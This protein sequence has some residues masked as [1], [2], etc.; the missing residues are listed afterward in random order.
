MRRFIVFFLAAVIAG[1]GL[2]YL[3]FNDPAAPAG[4]PLPAFAVAPLDGRQSFDPARLDGPYLLNIWGSWCAPCRLEHAALMALE[5]EG[6]AIYGLSWRDDPADANAFLD[7][8]GDPYR[9]VMRIDQAA[10]DALGASGAPETLVVADGR[11]LARWPGPLTADALRNRIYPALEQA[12][13]R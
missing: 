7:E 5:A 9:A 12:A 8:L 11:V 1:A 3:Y 2:S 4:E 10:V 13:R 6:I